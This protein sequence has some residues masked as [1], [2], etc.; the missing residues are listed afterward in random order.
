MGLYIY[1]WTDL[2]C[3]S[4]Y[5][6][7]RSDLLSSCWALTCSRAKRIR[8]SV[9]WSTVM[10]Q[11]IRSKFW[12]TVAVGCLGNSTQLNF[13]LEI[14][15]NCTVLTV[16]V[17]GL[18]ERGELL[19]PGTLVAYGSGI[20]RE[21]SCFRLTREAATMAKVVRTAPMPQE[22]T[23]AVVSGSVARITRTYASR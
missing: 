4:R 16:V 15:D 21:M 17:P 2:L 1:T 14:C 10:H 12:L 13:D 9:C 11:F 6:K 19:I 18:E 3:C 7:R 22:K 8:D 20:P 23:S 5:V